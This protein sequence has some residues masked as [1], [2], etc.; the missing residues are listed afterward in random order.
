VR[1]TDVAVVGAGPAGIAAALA[2]RRAGA[3]V[4][5]VDE[6]AQA[7]GQIYRQPPSAFQVLA[8]R[9]LG[10]DYVRAR[11]MTRDLEGASA[12]LLAHTLVWGVAGTDTLLLHQEGGGADALRA[13]AIVVAA[14]AYDRPIAF[15]GWTLPGVWT[16]GG[17][18]ALLKGQR[19]LA[20]QRVLVAGAGPLLLPVASALVAAGAA[21]VGVAE[22]TTRGAWVRQAH[23]MLGHWGRIGDAIR[24]EAAL[25]I[26]RVP[27]F[28]GHTVLRAEGRGRVERVTIAAV[29]RAWRPRAGT[30]RTLDVDLLCVGYGFLSAVELPALL[31]CE[32][33]YLPAQ[34][35]FVPRHTAEMAS[36]IPH[37]FVA[38]ETTGV[39]GAHL[40]WA[41]GTIAGVMAAR[42]VGH[43]GGAEAARALRAA[44]RR[45]HHEL[46]FARLLDDLFAMQ[47][48]IYDLGGPDTPLCRCEEVTR[49]EVEGAVRCGATSVRAVKGMTR[50]GQGPCQG[51]MC[52][53]L[54]AHVVAR[55][56]G[57]PLSE[58]LD[59]TPRP[60]I[61]P[62]P[63][64]VLAT[65]EHAV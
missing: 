17:A 18:Q 30:E 49:A 60:P 63:L 20:G 34:E 57:R 29:D 19:I 8:P 44:Q 3:Q 61:K 47:P 38:G 54:V 65:C 22:A 40:A 58:V 41:E 2:A 12:S 51:R 64:G 26:A 9:A 50:V 5:L 7:G 25:R 33:V 36:S 23:R 14:G 62:I 55:A 21:V 39:G 31:G 15:P 13:S 45:R 37:V 11:Q 4:T 59:I 1:Q 48:G 10:R 52:A 28:F 46:R 35:Q 27:R 16:A 53:H 6:Y 42:L 24:Y 32:M 56:T 43:R